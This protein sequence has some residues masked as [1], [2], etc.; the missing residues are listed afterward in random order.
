M[1]F[2]GEHYLCINLCQVNVQISHLA[3]VL[4][5]NEHEGGLG[6]KDHNPSQANRDMAD[7]IAAQVCICLEGKYPKI[8]YNLGLDDGDKPVK[9]EACPL[10]KYFGA[11]DN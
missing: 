4:T 5:T 7:A 11:Q 10:Y 1:K 3:A 2:T 8:I 9:L 6:F